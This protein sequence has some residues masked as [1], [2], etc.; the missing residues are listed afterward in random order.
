MKAGQTSGAALIGWQT[1]LAD[2]SLI[3]FMVTAAA[4]SARAPPKTRLDQTLAEPLA[5][6]RAGGSQTLGP[7]LA[8]QQPDHRQQLTITMHYRPG[9]QEAALASLQALLREAGAMGSLARVIVTPAPG[10]SED[11]TVASL[12]YDRAPDAGTA[13]S[14]R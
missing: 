6:W 8:E 11:E 14:L 7:W 13:R 4:M 12:A 2:L 3:L 9:G 5:V 10:A 1:L